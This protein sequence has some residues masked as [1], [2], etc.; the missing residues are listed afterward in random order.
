MSD[1]QLVNYFVKHTLDTMFEKVE[2]L[3]CGILPIM[4]IGVSHG[5]SH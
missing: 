1:S 2:A 3:N 5:W 4:E